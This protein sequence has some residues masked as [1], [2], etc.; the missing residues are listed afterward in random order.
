MPAVQTPISAPS[1]MAHLQQVACTAYLR[2][3]ARHG[4]VQKAWIRK[5]EQIWVEIV[6]QGMQCLMG[7]SEAQFP[8]TC[9]GNAAAVGAYGRCA[10]T[11][12]EIRNSVATT[13]PN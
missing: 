13:L 12:Q 7:V 4:P 9:I 10:S 1:V 11:S 3:H 6:M 5:R 8:R 2:T